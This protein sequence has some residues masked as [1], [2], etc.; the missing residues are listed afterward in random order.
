MKHILPT[1][2][3]VLLTMNSCHHTPSPAT[4]C[5]WEKEMSEKL[6]LLGHRNWI[7][8]TDMA[9]PLQSAPGITTLFADEEYTD[10]VRKVKAQIDASPHVFAHVYRDAELDY[11]SESD[12]PGVEELKAELATIY[13][14]EV[15]AITHEALL[16]KM[17]AASRLYNIV[18]I[19]TP[20]T[21]AY[22][23]TFFELDCRYWNAEKQQ[24]LD[25]AVKAE[26]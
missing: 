9:Y 23:S 20:L 17:D 18:I 25:N 3:L 1:L 16:E 14:T 24:R 12:M 10:V 6:P 8:V 5:G 19:K 13:G 26:E 11:I 7:V 2:L 4:E 21:M 22:T 15:Q